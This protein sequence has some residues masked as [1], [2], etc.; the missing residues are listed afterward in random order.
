MYVMVSAC[1]GDGQTLDKESFEKPNE[2][3]GKPSYFKEKLCDIS[4][5]KCRSHSKFDAEP[6][7]PD[8]DSALY[9]RLIADKLR[10]L[11]S[12][13]NTRNE[14]IASAFRT[15]CSE[16]KVKLSFKIFC[17]GQ[18]TAKEPF[19]I[20]PSCHLYI[21]QASCTCLNLG[22][23]SFQ[24]SFL[25][26]QLLITQCGNQTGRNTAI[27]LQRLLCSV[28]KPFHELLIGA[29]LNDNSLS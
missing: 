16:K 25:K 2:L 21:L 8:D 5:A 23:L 7:S 12:R 26:A 14:N 10:N 15:D 6:T 28:P 1:L 11:S 20:E 4:G 18:K 3:L 29:G 19:V 17:R 24:L 27:E 13:F 9:E 22:K